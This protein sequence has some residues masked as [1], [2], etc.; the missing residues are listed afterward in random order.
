MGEGGAARRGGGGGG[1]HEAAARAHG[2]G[3]GGRAR[4][5]AP[6][7]RRPPRCVQVCAAKRR[8][9]WKRAAGD[10]CVAGEAGA[11]ETPGAGARGVP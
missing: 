3:S 1:G 11:V 2:G 8:S 4:P 5:L 10:W 9:G 7:R 6:W